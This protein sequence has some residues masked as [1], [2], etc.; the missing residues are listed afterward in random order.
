MQTFTRYRAIRYRLCFND[1]MRYADGSVFSDGG[2][3]D[4]VKGCYI[5]SWSRA[6]SAAGSATAVVSF[7][8]IAN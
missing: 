2:I 4:S 6:V 8:R 7:D 5:G 1:I 3:W